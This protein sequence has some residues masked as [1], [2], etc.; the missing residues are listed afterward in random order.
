M[1]F[2]FLYIRELLVVLVAIGLCTATW[3]SLRRLYRKS[4][5]KKEKLI[6]IVGTLVFIGVVIVL[7]RWGKNTLLDL[8]RF[9]S[10]DYEY[11]SGTTL[12]YDRTG[13]AEGIDDK[14]VILLEENTGEIIEIHALFSRFR[15]GEKVEAYYLPNSHLGV[16]VEYS[17]D[18]IE[19]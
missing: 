12:N 4:E 2:A 15:E 5:E 6:Y 17:G 1:N 9:I 7:G 16:I 14:Q 11:V 18:G 3:I 8:P 19:Q 10:R 13:R